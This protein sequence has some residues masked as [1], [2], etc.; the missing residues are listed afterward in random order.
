MCLT[1]A[2]KRSEVHIAYPEP[3]DAG[4]QDW[5]LAK[6]ELVIARS[7]VWSS[8]DPAEAVEVELSLEGLEAS[9]QKPPL[10]TVE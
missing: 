8:G 3:L 5:L 7:T 6:K 9:L 2:G 1:V 4:S 10:N